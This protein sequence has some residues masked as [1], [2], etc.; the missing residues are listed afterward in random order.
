MKRIYSNYSEDDY[1]MISELA[2]ELG[3]TAS[4]FQ[5]YCVMLYAG[6][7]GKTTDSGELVNELLIN[8]GKIPVG[9]TFIVSALL[10]DKWPGLERNMK[11][12]LAK[13]VALYVRKN[14]NFEVYKAVRGQTTIYKRVGG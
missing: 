9:S 10:P 13:Q 1:G 3:F 2:K 12:L 11:T 14:N 4:A 5:H 7:K 6:S 8:M